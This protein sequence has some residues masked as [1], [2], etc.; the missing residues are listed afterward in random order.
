MESQDGKYIIKLIDD[1]HIQMLAHHVLLLLM[2]QLDGSM[3][4]DTLQERY[5][6]LF[7]YGVTEAELKHDLKNLVQ[8][9]HL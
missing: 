4:L 8:V 3:S 1:T 6:H 2:E 9:S 5:R 7:G